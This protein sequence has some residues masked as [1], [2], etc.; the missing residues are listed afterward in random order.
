MARLCL[1]VHKPSVKNN[2]R[3]DSIR[4]LHV[5]N[6]APSFVIFIAAMSSQLSDKRSTTAARFNDVVHVVE[7]V[8][9]DHFSDASIRRD[10]ERPVVGVGLTGK[11]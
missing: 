5:H 6:F 8:R 3:G 4:H 10:M 9:S 1:V 11:H 2:V 7:T